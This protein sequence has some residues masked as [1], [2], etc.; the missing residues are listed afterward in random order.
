MKIISNKKFKRQF[1]KLKKSKQEKFEEKINIFLITP[2]D[3]ILNNHPLHGKYKNYRS[4]N[5]SGNLRAIYK[6]INNN[7]ALFVEI[8]THSQLYN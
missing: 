6:L 5:I 3:S 1:Q 7:T 2:F 4:I 8:G